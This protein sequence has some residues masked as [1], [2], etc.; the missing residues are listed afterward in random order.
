M[1]PD[2]NERQVATVIVQP[3]AIVVHIGPLQAIIMN[4][5]LLIFN[6]YHAL[7]I[8]LVSHWP[9]KIERATIDKKYH[10][11]RCFEVLLLELM[12]Y[13]EWRFNQLSPELSDILE[14]LLSTQTP[15]Q[16]QSLLDGSIRLNDF[17]E[18]ISQISLGLGELLNSDED[19]AGL[20]LSSSRSDVDHEEA[21]LLLESIQTNVFFSPFSYFLFFLFTPSLP[22][23]PSPPSSLILFLSFRI[24]LP[25]LS[26]F[27]E[28][29]LSFPTA[30]PSILFLVC[31]LLNLLWFSS[32]LFYVDN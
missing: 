5:E 22:P 26:R 31:I 32:C 29:S 13:L 3:N 15:E 6:L 2:A 7:T 17:Y 20:Y 10:E 11:L 24:S 28:L 14:N 21:E 18:E 9:V 12:H 27:Q 25:L 4:N 8:S 19:M 23:F 30:F 1:R 16:L